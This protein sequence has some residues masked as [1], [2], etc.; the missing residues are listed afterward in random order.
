MRRSASWISLAVAMAVLGAA[1]SLAAPA[2]K[3]ANATRPGN[4]WIEPPT[5]ISL[6]FEWRID[7]DENRNARVDVSYRKKG[8]RD[9]HKT[10]SHRLPGVRATGPTRIPT[11]SRFGLGT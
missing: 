2:A 4:F 3:P 1:P 9:W 10:S 5:L 7:G 11:I 8:E 6:G